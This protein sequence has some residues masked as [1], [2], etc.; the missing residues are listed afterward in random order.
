MRKMILATGVA[1]VGS[2]VALVGQSRDGRYDNRGD[3][4]AGLPCVSS[5]ESWAELHL[6]GWFLE[7]A[8]QPLWMDHWLLGST[9]V[10]ERLLGGPAL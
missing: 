10:C 3:P 8:R 2:S 7:L 6:G 9:A 5:S 1:M 4:S